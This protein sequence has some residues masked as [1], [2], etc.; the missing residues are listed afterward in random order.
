MRSCDGDKNVT[1]RAGERQTGHSN[2]KG[3]GPPSPIR[4]PQGRQG[5]PQTRVAA[6]SGRRTGGSPC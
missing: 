2:K 6:R 3:E 1:R 5:A 4:G